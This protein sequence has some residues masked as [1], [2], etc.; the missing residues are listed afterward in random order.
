MLTDL[1]RGA[2]ALLMLV[3]GWI[4]KAKFDEQWPRRREIA[5]AF[6]QKVLLAM[7]PL[8]AIAFV[9]YIALVMLKPDALTKSDFAYGL[10]AAILVP[11]AALLNFVNQLSRSLERVIDVLSASRSNL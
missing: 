7:M 4:L 9:G 1:T 6:A 3:L 8:T 10:V 5:S 2:I 11:L